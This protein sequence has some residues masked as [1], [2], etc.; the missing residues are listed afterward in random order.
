[1]ARYIVYILFFYRDEER[2]SFTAQENNVK[3]IKMEYQI[4]S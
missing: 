1:M 3:E 4:N 2:R